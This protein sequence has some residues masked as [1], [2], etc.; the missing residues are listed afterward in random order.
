MALH[1]DYTMIEDFKN[2]VYIKEGRTLR[3]N[4]VTEVL[5]MSTMACGMRE[6]TAKNADEFYARLTVVQR[7]QGGGWL[8][9]NGEPRYITRDEVKRHVGLRTN[10]TAWTE[11]QFIKQQAGGALRDL[12]RATTD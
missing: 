5:A 7:L 3:V 1:V 6:I 8:I 12:K 11:A 2:L 4:P 9:E 10:A